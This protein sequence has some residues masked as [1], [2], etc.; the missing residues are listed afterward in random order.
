M[1]KYGGHHLT[2]G[3][4]K[5]DEEQVQLTRN[6]PQCATVGSTPHQCSVLTQV[7]AWIQ[8]EATIAETLTVENSTIEIMWILQKC[9]CQERPESWRKLFLYYK[10]C[11]ILKKGFPF[12]QK[13]P[14]AKDQ[15]RERKREGRQSFTESQVTLTHTRAFDVQ[16]LQLCCTHYI[17]WNPP[18]SPHHT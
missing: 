7:F 12:A 10:K 11:M 6:G 13:S 8:S 5:H 15:R 2:K 18:N 14:E 3:S 16:V 17:S 1:E 9:P 4:S